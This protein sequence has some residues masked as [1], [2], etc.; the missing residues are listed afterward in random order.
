MAT[1]AAVVAVQVNG[2]QGDS[3]GKVKVG[4]TKTEALER[5]AATSGG[6]FDKNGVGLLAT[7]RI[8]LVGGP[9]VFKETQQLY[10]GELRCCSR[11][12]SFLYS[13]QFNLL[14]EYSF[15]NSVVS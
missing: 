12:H 5:L 9:Y 7:D 11:I 3:L 2:V 1:E 15:C 4:D 8:T 14:L 6:L 10:N 13:I